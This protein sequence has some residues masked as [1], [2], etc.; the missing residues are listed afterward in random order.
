MQAGPVADSA[1][2]V[3]PAHLLGDGGRAALRAAGQALPVVAARVQPVARGQRRAEDPHGAG[4]DRGCHPHRAGV[5]ADND[6][7]AL[8]HSREHGRLRAQVQRRQQP[9]R[10]AAP[11]VEHPL[12]ADHERAARKR[13]RQLAP[14]RPLLDGHPADGTSTTGRHSGPS[15]RSPSAGSASVSAIRGARSTSRGPIT[16]SAARMPR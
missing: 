13:R 10:A 3:P 16:P 9:C 6:A 8:S 11:R 7:A 1:P 5:R 2:A 12:L 4:A 14:V 15:V